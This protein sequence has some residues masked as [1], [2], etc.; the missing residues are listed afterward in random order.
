MPKGGG[1]AYARGAMKCAALAILLAAVPVRA[2]TIEVRVQDEQGT[3][4]PA[5]TV[6]LAIESGLRST[7]RRTGESGTATFV[8]LKPGTYELGAL[9]APGFVVPGSN[10]LDPPKRVTLVRDDDRVSVVLQV[11]RGARLVARMRPARSDARPGSLSLVGE[12]TGSTV[13]AKLEEG[14]Y[15]ELTL[16]PDRWHVQFEPPAGWTTIGVER[17]GAAWRDDVLELPPNAVDTF[18]D[19][20]IAAPGTI[21]GRIV[22]NRPPIHIGLQLEL[23]APGPWAQAQQAAGWNVPRLVQAR[24]DDHGDWSA[25]LPD[26]RWHVQPAPNEMSGAAVRPESVVVDVAS[27]GSARADFEITFPDGEGDQPTVLVTVEDPEGHAV[28][29]DVAAF[30]AGTRDVVE[31]SRAAPVALLGLAAGSYTIEAVHPDYLGASAELPDFEPTPEPR[32]VKLRLRQGAV[33]RVR[34]ADGKGIPA[35]GVRITLEN[36][37]ERERAQITDASGWVSFT[38]LPGGNYTLAAETEGGKARFSWEESPLVQLTEQAQAERHLRILPAATITAHLACAQGESLPPKVR[39]RVVPE[40]E[41]EAPV[42]TDVL[43]QANGLLEAGPVD[44]GNVR[45]SFL[46]SEFDRATWALGTEDAAESARVQIE[47]EGA[48][49]L[50]TIQIHCGPRALLRLGKESPPI[51]LSRGPARVEG[52]LLDEFD[53]VT[54]KARRRVPLRTLSLSRSEDALEVAGLPEGTVELAVTLCSPSAP[55]VG[56][57]EE[58]CA[59][60]EGVSVRPAHWTVRVPA[61]LG[62]ISQMS[63]EWPWQGEAP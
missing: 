57:G 12:R 52:V 7:S 4:M 40:A 22:A 23:L 60:A 20:E 18:L 58:A 34:A 30:R 19:W 36:G 41:A 43:L 9:P 14:R 10:P 1:E 5:Q 51:D 47:G 49:D 3:A 21:Q 26:G 15:T 62:K 17:D 29:A 44:A 11:R 50:G 31:S 45:V 28:S 16:L 55:R 59:V 39:V 27:G 24:T 56:K 46:P 63:V 25:L 33:L 2:A 37:D 8:D 35:E 48:T 53:P 32:H 13:S 38:G 61:I 42:E 6:S 54:E